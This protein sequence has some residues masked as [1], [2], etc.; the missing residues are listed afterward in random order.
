MKKLLLFVLLAGTNIVTFAQN[1]S[2]TA[3]QTV[4]LN[5]TNAIEITF[6]GTGNNTGADVNLNFV[7]VNDYANGVESSDQWLKVRS[8]KDFTVAVKSNDEYF[9]YS[10]SSTSVPKMKVKDVLSLLVS[11]NKTGGYISSPYSFYKFR[12]IDDNNSYLLKNCDRGGDQTFAVKYKAD[13]GFQFPA[14]TYSVEVVY[15][16]T[17]Q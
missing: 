16:A 7:T 10:G 17:Q 13:P 2:S 12:S 8:N 5:L 14:G 9:S 1:V 6:T 15:T 4:K 11:A 3:S